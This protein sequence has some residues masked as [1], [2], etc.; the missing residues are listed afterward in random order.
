MIGWRLQINLNMVGSVKVPSAQ[1]PTLASCSPQ[2]RREAAWLLTSQQPRL[3]F[4]VGRFRAALAN[5]PQLDQ[6]LAGCPAAQP[7]ERNLLLARFFYGTLW[8]NEDF[9]IESFRPH[10]RTQAGIEDASRTG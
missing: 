5:L 3:V 4:I 9:F 1:G 8:N 6:A 7:L 10:N 2:E